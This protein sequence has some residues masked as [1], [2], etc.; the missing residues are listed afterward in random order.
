VSLQFLAAKAGAEGPARGV[1]G[2]D[3][4]GRPELVHLYQLGLY[5]L[6]DIHELYGLGRVVKGEGEDEIVFILPAGDVR[7]L[8]TM[9]DAYGFE[10][11]PEFMEMCYAICR[12]AEAREG[13]EF[14]FIA[15]FVP[16]G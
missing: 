7:A 5:T 10:Y 12:F 14:R 15:N 2:F 4:S 9:A 11:E 16:V 8:K 3:A 6:A 13:D 1:Y